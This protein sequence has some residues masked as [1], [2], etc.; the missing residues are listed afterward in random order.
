MQD[1]EERVIVQLIKSELAYSLSKQDRHCSTGESDD[2]SQAAES[3]VT[4]LLACL[5]KWRASALARQT[6]Q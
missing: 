2:S 5:W 6:C 1:S 4:A 3:K